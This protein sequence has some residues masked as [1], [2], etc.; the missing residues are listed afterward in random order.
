LGAYYVPY[1][2]LGLGPMT[3]LLVTRH[4]TSITIHL[5]VHL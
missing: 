3:R 4:L 5:P 2:S 1:L